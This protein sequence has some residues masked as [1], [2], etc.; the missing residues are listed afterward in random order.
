MFGSQGQSL[1][2]QNQVKQRENKLI[3]VA[4]SW[5]NVKV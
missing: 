2:N 1:G 5:H 3:I 4:D